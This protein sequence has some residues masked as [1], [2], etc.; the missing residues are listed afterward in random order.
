M[1]HV[2][3][4]LIPTGITC[5]EVLTF[6]NT[7]YAGTGLREILPLLKSGRRL[8]LPKTASKD[9]FSLITNCKRVVTQSSLILGY[10]Y[11]GLGWGGAYV[12]GVGVGV[13][14]YRGLGLGVHMYRGLG[15]GCICTGVG[16]GVHMYRGLGWG[17]HMY[18]GWGGG[19]YVQGVG[20]GGAYVQGLGGGV[21]VS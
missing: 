9:L 6:G 13:H 17:V 12:Q 2:L 16:V 8:P 1:C 3:W 20:V 14:M 21:E 5:W 18:T 19:A 4:L 11:R 7:P 10:M 15:W